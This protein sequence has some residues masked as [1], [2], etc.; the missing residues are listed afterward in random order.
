MRQLE[1]FAV[2]QVKVRLGYE[3]LE[4]LDVGGALEIF[5]GLEKFEDV[6]DPAREAIAAC[7]QWQGLETETAELEPMERAERMWSALEADGVFTGKPRMC[8][9]KGLAA[10]LIV[11]LDK[12]QVPGENGGLCSGSLM[13]ETGRFREAETWYRNVLDEGSGHP[14]LRRQHGDVLWRMGRR[15]EARVEYQR[16]LLEAPSQTPLH[17]LPDSQ[18]TTIIERHG[19]E[20]APV[21]GWIARIFQVPKWQGLP[22]S[23]P[24]LLLRLL[25]DAETARRQGRHEDMVAVRRDLSTE[26][27]EVLSAYMSRLERA[28]F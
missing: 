25:D 18:L 28:W 19:S 16:A 27:P 13:M 12:L 7:A 22:R 5:R 2:D 8:L 15:L 10:R 14:A 1:L 24:V 6:E 26:A 11:D 4:E 23:R 21:Y 17:D 3:A 9:R 20:M